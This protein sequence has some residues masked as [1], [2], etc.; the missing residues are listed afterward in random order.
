MD[1]LNSLKIDKTSLTKQ[2]RIRLDKVTEIEIIFIKRL[3]KE[4]YAV[5][6]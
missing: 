5:K 6:N 1:E 3:N 4:N 2:T